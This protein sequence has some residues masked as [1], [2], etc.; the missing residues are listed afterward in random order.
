MTLLDPHT[1]PAFPGPGFG[2]CFV[3]Q[4]QPRLRL[5]NLPALKERSV[6]HEDF[7][8]ARRID[9]DRAGGGPALDPNV[10]PAVPEQGHR[11]DARAPRIW[12][13]QHFI[14]IDADIRPVGEVELP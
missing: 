12:N 7:H 11:L 9:W 6:Q 14:R 5:K 4:P 3:R 2:L 1:R 10:L 8:A 13:E